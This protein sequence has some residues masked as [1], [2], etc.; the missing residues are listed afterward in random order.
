[1]SV[2]YI[3][4]EGIVI[5]ES[6]EE[7]CFDT[8]N[9][10]EDSIFFMLRMDNPKENSLI[11]NLFSSNEE[12]IYSFGI[13][14]DS[15]NELYLVSRKKAN[16]GYFYIDENN[17]CKYFRNENSPYKLIKR[18][19]KE[20]KRLLHNYNCYEKNEIYV[21][22]LYSFR[23]DYIDSYMDLY[24]KDIYENHTVLML[25]EPVS[26]VYNFSKGF[27]IQKENFINDEIAMKYLEDNFEVVDLGGVVNVDFGD[28]EDIF[29]RED[30]LQEF[31]DSCGT[32]TFLKKHFNKMLITV[33][34]NMLERFV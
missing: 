34:S 27:Y 16:Y 26:K 21:S 18:A 11:S 1:M 13:S 25:G 10:L 6:I 5:C 17:L 19:K 20:L 31:H 22:T 4:K 14:K 30:V 23:G 8:E 12:R 9:P 29:S 3:S 32:N 2:G 15:N 24:G 28:G 7:C 33:S